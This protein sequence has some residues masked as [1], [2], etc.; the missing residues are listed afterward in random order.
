MGLRPLYIFYS[1]IAN[2]DF[3]RH[4]LQTLV[5]PRAEGVKAS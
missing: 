1:F 3:R 4:I 2:I 5:D